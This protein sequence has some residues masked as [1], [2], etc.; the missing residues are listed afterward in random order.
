[1][2]SLLHLQVQEQNKSLNIVFVNLS[3]F[4]NWMDRKMFQIFLFIIPLLYPSIS[5]TYFYGDGSYFSGSV[6]EEGQPREGAFY[7]KKESLIYNGSFVDGLYHGVGSWFGGR[8]ESYQGEFRRG[9]ASG[10]GVWT[11]MNTGERVEGQFEN[12]LVNGKAVWYKPAQGV[13]L[14]GVFKRGHA[15]G[16]GVVYWDGTGY[17]LSSQF[18]KGYPHGQAVLSLPNNTVA[19]EGVFTNGVT[20]QEVEQ[21]LRTLFTF[22]TEKPFRSRMMWKF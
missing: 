4:S 1:L 14:E 13:R 17:R 3:K 15:H 18:K 22:F 9:E 12:G 8:G 6:D 21:E 19:W 5:L 10:G 2:R 16:P 20:E 7:E 11:N